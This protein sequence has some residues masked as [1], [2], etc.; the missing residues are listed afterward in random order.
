MSEWHVVSFSGG[1][2]STAMLL[3]MLELG[4]RVDEIIFC[5]TG[6]EFPQMYEHIEKVE[7]YIGR[8]ITRLKWWGGSYE[9]EFAHH[10][11]TRGKFQDK[12]GKGW[13][14]FRNR[15]CTQYFKERPSN[16]FLSQYPAGSYTLYIGIAYDE[17]KRH[18]NI[19]N[20]VQHPLFEWE[21]TEKM[22]LEYCFAKGFDFGG[23]YDHF[24]RLGCFCCPLQRIGSWK[25]L[26]TFYPDL[27]ARCLQ[28]EQDC[29]WDTKLSSGLK[30]KDL[31]ARFS[32]EDDA[33]ARK[34][35]LFDEVTA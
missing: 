16:K 9:W 30:L 5:D 15:W 13:A 34:I 27:W 33:E 8:K 28:M 20:H 18:K 22:A 6:V 23:L 11:K 1:K 10:K 7:R 12:N 26:Y 21:W 32:R 14:S 35:S 3:R 25:N 29:E 31:D 4:M 17:P 24:P 2:D 19:P